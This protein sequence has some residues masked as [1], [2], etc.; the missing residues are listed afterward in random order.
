MRQNRRSNAG[1]TDGVPHIC[2]VLWL[3]IS[4]RQNELADVQLVLNG[5]GREVSFGLGSAFPSTAVPAQAVMSTGQAGQ[6]ETAGPIFLLNLGRG[7]LCHAGK[8]IP[9]LMAFVD[10]TGVVKVAWRLLDALGFLSR[11]YWL[12]WNLERGNVRSVMV[13]PIVTITTIVRAMEH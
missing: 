9:G 3:V 7:V 4:V 8:L 1:K 12:H 6:D 2:K 13:R 5:G 11:K 10:G